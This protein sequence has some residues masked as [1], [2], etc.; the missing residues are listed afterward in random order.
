MVQLTNVL[1]AL[2]VASSA[3]S[4]LAKQQHIAQK[5]S[6][7]TLP[8]MQACVCIEVLYVVTH[9]LIAPTVESPWW[10]PVQRR[11]Y[12]RFFVPPP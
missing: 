12:N 7:S 8:W 6:D 9:K 1:M 2:L 10:S 5:I 11:C 4:A 3:T